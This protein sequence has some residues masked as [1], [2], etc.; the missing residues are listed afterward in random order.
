MIAEYAIRMHILDDLG[1]RENGRP[2]RPRGRLRRGRAVSFS[3]RA[4]ELKLTKFHT[5]EFV[6]LRAE[7]AEPEVEKES[8]GR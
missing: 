4:R 8:E 2:P 3:E 1:Y 7:L 6:I 5:V